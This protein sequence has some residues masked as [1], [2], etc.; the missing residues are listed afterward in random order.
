MMGALDSIAANVHA[1]FAKVAPT[2]GVVAYDVGAKH[3]HTN[4]APPYIVW[5]AA[6]GKTS[7]ELRHNG[8]RTIA[9]GL[10]GKPNHVELTTVEL[11]IWGRDYS[12]TDELWKG[13]KAAIARVCKGAHAFGD[14]TW[15]KQDKHDYAKRGELV[16]Q[17]VELHIPVNEET[18]ATGQIDT[19]STSYS[20]DS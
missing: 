4:K 15:P 7:Y 20:I 17:M 1:D 5:R 8:P 10:V 11:W 18:W 6:K 9:P 14:F 16:V 2:I 13:L 12:A 3:L 19:V